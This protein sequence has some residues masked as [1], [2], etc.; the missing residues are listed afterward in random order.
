MR[1]KNAVIVAILAVA[2]R[3]ESFSG[4]GFVTYEEFGAVGDGK[5]DDQAAIVAA[6][7]AANARGVPVRADGVRT[8]FIG[9]GCRVVPIRTDVDFGTARFVIDDRTVDDYDVP[10]FRVEASLPAFSVEGVASLKRH[11]E[12]LGV[13]L[14]VPCL[15]IAVNEGVKQF[16]REG[17]NKNNGS[18]QREMFLADENGVID[19][20]TSIR[21]DFAALTSLTAYPRDARTLTVKGGV[22]TTVANQA[23][24]KYTYYKRNIEV[25]RSNVRIEGLRHLVVGEIDHGA[26]YT[27]FLSIV[28]AADV[29]VTGCVFTAHKTYGTIGSA[30]V[31]VSMGSYDLNVGS[32][33]RVSYLGCSQTTDLNDRACWGLFG[34]NYC[35]DL[36]LDGCSFS[37]FDA[38]AGVANATIRNSK[39]GYMGIRAIGTGTLL[40]EKTHVKASCLVELRCDYGSTWD[41]DVVIRDCVFTPCGGTKG[42]PYSLLSAWNKG[43]HDFGYACR[44]PRRLVV[45]GLRIDDAGLSDGYPGVY[46]FSDYDGRKTESVDVPYPL[47][48]PQE[49]ELNNIIAESGKS[50]RLCANRFL[51]RG[52]KIVGDRSMLVVDECH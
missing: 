13:S 9:R 11:Q 39:I 22:F 33:I 48:P 50:M 16:I 31:P 20:T 46:V 24:S 21:Q 12:S 42:R 18:G 49:L 38:H 27:G 34:S 45:D 25:N 47:Q 32:A 6:H 30:G 15:L 43:T 1:T 52:L 41:G 8:Y 10:V 29:T 14:P 4:T 35:R 40:L 7:E 5:A 23:P 26:P 51:Y 36:L 17:F 19:P 37:R 2:A 28:H 3:L 44:M